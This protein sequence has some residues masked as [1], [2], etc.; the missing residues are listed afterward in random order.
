MH[1]QSSM[2]ETSSNLRESALCLWETFEWKLS[3]IA[4]NDCLLV[5]Y[6]QSELESGQCSLLDAF[7]EAAEK[8]KSKPKESTSREASKKEPVKKDAAQT[9]LPPSDKQACWMHDIITSHA[10]TLA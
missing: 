10:G 3:R 2:K 7:Q 8:R 5:S 6:S 9:P 4:E 1:Q